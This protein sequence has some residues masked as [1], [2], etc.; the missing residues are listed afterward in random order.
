MLLMGSSESSMIISANKV[1]QKFC[2]MLKEIC[3]HVIVSS[4][5]T[6]PGTR[7]QYAFDVEKL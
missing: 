4:G 6:V 5:I 3:T 1:M 7:S 2:G